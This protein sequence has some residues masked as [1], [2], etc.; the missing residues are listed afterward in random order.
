MTPPTDEDVT[1]EWARRAE[2]EG[3]ARVMRASQPSRLNSQ[4]T[5]AT[6]RIVAD[7]L[8]I[9][10]AGLRRPVASA[11]EVGCGVGRLTPTLADHARHVTAIDMTPRMLDSAKAACA[12]LTHVDFAL[13][14]AEELPWRGSTFDVG[15]SVWV[16]MHLLDEEQLSRV[17][18][19]LAES[20]R[21]VVLIEYEHAQIPVSRWSRLR[22][23]DYYLSLLTGAYVVEERYLD[24]GGDRSTAALIRL[25]HP[26]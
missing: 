25:P 7:Y 11:L 2:R 16:L 23:L 4:V 8:R 17:C 20:S 18:T 19:S 14:R 26:A 5:D 10:A 24:Y 21:Y 12:G 9:A 13:A 1:R 6:R 15:V 22:A 3:L